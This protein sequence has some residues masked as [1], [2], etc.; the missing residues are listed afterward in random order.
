MPK[1]YLLPGLASGETIGTLAITEDNGKWDF[2]GIECQAE[3][4]GDGWILNG[5]KMFVIDGHIADLIVVAARTRKGRLA[6]RGQR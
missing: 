1:K 5:H 4:S 6:L 2:S 3:Q